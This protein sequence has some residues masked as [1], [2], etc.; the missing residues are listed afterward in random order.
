MYLG[1]ACAEFT[2]FHHHESAQLVIIQPE[3]D[4][5]LWKDFP[6]NTLWHSH[7]SI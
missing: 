5:N 7:V 4:G 1:A 6:E 3:I 2:F